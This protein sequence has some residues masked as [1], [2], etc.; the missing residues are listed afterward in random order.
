M[1]DRNDTEVVRQSA[2]FKKLH[3]RNAEW[4][5]NTASTPG[6]TKPN[7][8]LQKAKYILWH[9]RNSVKDTEMAHRKGYL[10]WNTSS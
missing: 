9:P 6:T 2:K 10:L 5:R 1:D 7:L 4:A 8:A 3:K